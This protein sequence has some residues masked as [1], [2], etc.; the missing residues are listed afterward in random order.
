[1][2]SPD[3]AGAVIRYEKLL[4]DME[5]ALENGPWLLGNEFSLADISFASYM[6][7][8]LFFFTLLLMLRK[9]FKFHANLC[10]T[11]NSKIL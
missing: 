1:M 8:P 2:D 10:D 7:L 9:L 3:F 6:A 4:D 11:D 5:S